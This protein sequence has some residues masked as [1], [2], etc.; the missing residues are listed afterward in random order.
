MNLLPES[1]IF[2]VASGEER[3]ACRW[4]RDVRLG[5]GVPFAFG[6]GIALTSD[7][8]LVSV[9]VVIGLGTRTPATTV[10][11]MELLFAGILALMLVT[12]L[13]KHSLLVVCAYLTVLGLGSILN[14]AFPGAWGNV[15]FYSLCVITCFRL[16]R[17]CSLPLV[18][19]SILAFA[20]T[21]GMLS[22]LPL[23]QPAYAGVSVFNLILLGALCWFGLNLR[24]QYRL[25]VRLHEVQ[26]QLQEQ[27]ARNAEL[28][29]E[30]ER[31]RIARDIHDVLSHS[32][33][34]LSIQLQAARHLLTHN[35]ERLASKLDDMAALLRES[36]T[37][38]RQAVGLLRAQLAAHARSENLGESLSRLANTFNER[39]GI[40]CHF[41]ESGAPQQVSAQQWETLHQALREMLTNAHR[42]GAAETAEI[43]LRWQATSL[44]LAVHDNGQGS[45]Q[46][47]PQTESINVGGHHGIEGMRERAIALDGEV[48]AGSAV[49]GGFT[50]TLH[51]PL[52][53]P[54]A[55]A[56]QKERTA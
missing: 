14:L 30:H 27:M 31:T 13:L 19:L 45:A 1:A 32:L 43:T 22:F 41:S 39:T 37:E 9:L 34:V 20:Y 56:M 15:G 38:S 24:A 50:V 51:L 17:R 11:L 46:P 49:E 4:W 47:A 2:E 53:P 12:R 33:A 5:P 6:R 29:A 40:H 35:P 25:V 54:V 23:P 36:I 10:I 44:S 48:V 28:A 18:S 42:H 7:M 16:P 3:Q 55:S 52:Q 26:M 8:I 21:N